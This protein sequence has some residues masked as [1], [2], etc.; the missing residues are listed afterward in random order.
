VSD[1]VTRGIRVRVRSLYVPEQS[2]PTA[3]R[4]FF[5]YTVNISNEG[6]ETAQLVSRRWTITDGEGTTEIVDGPGVV[7]EQPVLTPGGAFEYTSFCPLPTAVGS[8]HGI[9]RMVTADGGR[10]DALIAPFTLAVPHSLN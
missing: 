6:S 1:T 5:A 10:F 9:Y 4:Y 7:G 2:A 8:M 3:G